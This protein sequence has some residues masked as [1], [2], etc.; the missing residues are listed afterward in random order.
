MDC[1]LRTFIAY[2]DATVARVAT[3]GISRTRGPTG[4]GH[5]S[6]II[7]YLGQT[8]QR[9]A[10]GRSRRVQLAQESGAVLVGVWRAH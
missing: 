4:S 2:P 7:A 5:V 3:K 1:G 6:Q 10:N 9:T 8:E